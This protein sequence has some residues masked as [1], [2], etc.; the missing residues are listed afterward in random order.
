MRRIRD[1]AIVC[2]ITSII[3][4]I[5]GLVIWAYTSLFEEIYAGHLR[6][7]AHYSCGTATGDELVYK[8]KPGRCRFR[9]YEFDTVLSI[10]S[11]GFRNVLADRSPEIV[12]LGDSHAMGWGVAD[13]EVFSS[14]LERESGYRTR[15]LAIPS[16]ATPRELMALKKFLAHSPRYVV[17]QYCDNDLSENKRYMEDPSFLA[18]QAVDAAGVFRQGQANFLRRH[19]DRAVWRGITGLGEV[20]RSSKGF[21][22]RYSLANKSL[23]EESQ[24]FA[25]IV[26]S[27][28]EQL[29]YSTLVVL[30]SN[31]FGLNRPAFKAEFEKALASKTSLNFVVLD[32][33]SLL[34]RSDYF[35][36][37]DHLNRMGHQK[38]GIALARIV[39]TLGNQLR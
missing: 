32:T 4:L 17:I 7:M 30:E 11:D 27:F 28:S 8:L 23:A 20:L 2:G 5:S 25:S 9:N 19:K 36:F 22:P 33:S 29:K 31:H 14:V 26:H 38:L 18:K 13:G 16:W 39:K 6:D 10:D 35:F 24:V 15:N 12:V 37:D 3:L 34:R 1:I 21:P